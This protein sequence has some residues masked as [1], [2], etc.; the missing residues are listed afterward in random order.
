MATRKQNGVPRTPR[1]IPKVVPRSQVPKTRAV[2]PTGRVDL[3]AI[4]L[5]ERAVSIHGD[6]PLRAVYGSYKKQIDGALRQHL[7][8]VRVYFDGPKPYLATP[9][10]PEVKVRR[11]NAG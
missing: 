10:P 7:G 8:G 6:L 2:D 3:L 11:R 1:A 9:L 5:L 4:R